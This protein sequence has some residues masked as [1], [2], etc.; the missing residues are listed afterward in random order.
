MSGLQNGRDTDK[1]EHGFEIGDRVR[2][3]QL[4]EISLAFTAPEDLPYYENRKIGTTGVII[5]KGLSH[6][7]GAHTERS[8]HYQI[9]T[10]T[11]EEN[12]IT[13]V[14][15]DELELLQTADFMEEEVNSLHEWLQQ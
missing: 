10:D 3:Y 1:F 7:V 14:W 2:I 8:F 9:K 15:G 5:K 12:R 4:K 13:K 11:L 6:Q